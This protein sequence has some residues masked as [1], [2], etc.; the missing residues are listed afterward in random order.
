MANRNSGTKIHKADK[1]IYQ[2]GRSVGGNMKGILKLYGDE[3]Q[4]RRVT[5]NAVAIGDYFD[6]DFGGFLRNVAKE[7]GGAFIGR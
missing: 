7:T 3:K 5:V 4:S 1:G 6:K 2:T